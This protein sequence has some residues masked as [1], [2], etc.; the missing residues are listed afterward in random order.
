MNVSRKEAISK[1]SQFP[2]NLFNPLTDQMTSIVGHADERVS[3]NPYATQQGKVLKNCFAKDL[4][5]L[6]TIT[7]KEQSL[8]DT[9]SARVRP[10]KSIN[11]IARQGQLRTPGERLKEACEAKS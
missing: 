5:S 7:V 3:T 2:K 4:K 11:V 8:L 6:D 9:L 10:T 1:H